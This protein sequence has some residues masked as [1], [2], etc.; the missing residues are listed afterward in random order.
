[1]ARAR[2]RHRDRHSVVT[3]DTAQRVDAINRNSQAILV[4]SGLE[5]A[6]TIAAWIPTVLATD[7]GLVID[8]S[9]TIAAARIRVKASASAVGLT[10]NIKTRR[11]SRRIQNHK[12]RIIISYHAD[13]IP[14]VKLR[15]VAAGA[16]V[17]T[18]D[19][20]VP[21]GVQERALW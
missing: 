11:P 21:I 9:P 19:N 6:D 7:A 3:G 16:C 15:A 4:S 2:H 18:V 10:A 20:P 17:T 8:P 13:L 14:T 1:M 12:L 5:T